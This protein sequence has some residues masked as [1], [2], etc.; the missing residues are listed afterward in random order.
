MKIIERFNMAQS[1]EVGMTI[2]ELSEIDTD[3]QKNEI[4]W[5][6]VRYFSFIIISMSI[7]VLIGK[8]IMTVL[9]L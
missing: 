8:M 4:K 1:I 3:N 5:E 2:Q 7:F 9:K 6:I